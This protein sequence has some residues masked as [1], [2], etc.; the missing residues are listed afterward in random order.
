MDFAE[1][2]QT[3]LRDFAF[4][5]E[6]EKVPPLSECLPDYVK[7]GCEVAPDDYRLLPLTAPSLRFVNTSSHCLTDCMIDLQCKYR[8][9]IPDDW[10]GHIEKGQ[11]DL[12]VIGFNILEGVVLEILEI[13]ETGS[14]VDWAKP[15]LDSLHWERLL[16]QTV[17]DFGRSCEAKQIRL[18]PAHRYPVGAQVAA[19]PARSAEVREVLKQRYD[20][21]AKACGFDYDP[22]LD[23]FVLNLAGN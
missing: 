7:G 13:N 20:E 16:I 3:L 4:C 10:G 17:V 22:E 2:R 12:G 11:R 9:F 23:F 19:D 14:F 21:S 18:Q 15:K 6:K 1:L 5:V 8:Q